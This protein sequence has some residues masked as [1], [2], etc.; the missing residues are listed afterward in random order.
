VTTLSTADAG[1]LGISAVDAP[2]IPGIGSFGRH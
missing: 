1:N 2:Y